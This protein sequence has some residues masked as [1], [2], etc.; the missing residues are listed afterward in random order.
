MLAVKLVDVR[1][2]FKSDMNHLSRLLS[3]LKVDRVTE[4]ELT[5]LR[6]AKENLERS[7]SGLG[8]L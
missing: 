7:A 5:A 8:N 1:D 2:H 4:E 6:Q 3:K